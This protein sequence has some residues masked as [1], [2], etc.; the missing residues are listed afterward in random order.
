VRTTIDPEIEFNWGPTLWAATTV[1]VLGAVGNFVLSRPQLLAHGAVIA[2]V[3]SGFRSGYYQN[4]GYNAVIGTSLG[5]LLLTPALVYSRVV[6]VFNIDGTGD[7]LFVSVAFGFAWL[8]IATILL[9]PMAY[10][11]S[12]LGDFTRKRISGVLEY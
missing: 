9:L 8:I 6:W 10:I 11:G 5:T 1:V 7:T 2:G 4:S 12:L 3:V